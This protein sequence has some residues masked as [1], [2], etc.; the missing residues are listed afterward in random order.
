M[1]VPTMVQPQRIRIESCTEVAVVFN[2][3]LKPHLPIK[4]H[5]FVNTDQLKS[6][7][8][9]ADIAAGTGSTLRSSVVAA[10]TQ[11]SVAAGVVKD[12]RSPNTVGSILYPALA[13]PKGVAVTNT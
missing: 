8:W 9:H 10:L 4:A 2:L 6:F 11:P 7:H 1:Y 3:P 13:P 12:G 5:A